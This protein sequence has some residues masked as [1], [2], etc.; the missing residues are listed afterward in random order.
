MRC[1]PAF[2]ALLYQ[3]YSDTTER[4][5]LSSG[6]G[7]CAA[8]FDQTNEKTGRRG[9]CILLRTAVRP[10]PS[11]WRPFEPGGVWEGGKGEGDE[12]RKGGEVSKVKEKV[13]REE[14]THLLPC[15]NLLVRSREQLG[16]LLRPLLLLPLP[17]LPLERRS[18]PPRVRTVLLQPQLSED[19][20]R[21]YVLTGCECPPLRCESLSGFRLELGVEFGEGR[22]EDVLR[23]TE[24]GS[25]ESELLLSPEG[26]L[27]CCP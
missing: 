11:S 3:L 24:V 21:G 1:F 23:V 26:V 5:S 6:D 2:A 17:D 9:Y 27:G 10:C 16:Q 4:L 12:Q 20:R 8:L 25:F 22:R 19:L 13:K 14:S 7:Q 15:R 18:L